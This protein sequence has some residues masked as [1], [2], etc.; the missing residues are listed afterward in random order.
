MITE[1]TEASQPIWSNVITLTLSWIIWSPFQSAVW[2][3]F[4]AYLKELGAAPSI[5]ALISSVTTVAIIFARIFG[6]YLADIIG[7][8]KMIVIFTFFIA[9]SYYAYTWFLD[10]KWVLIVGVLSNIA[11]LYQPALNAIIADSLPKKRRGFG[12]M[13]TRLADI[14]TIFAPLI[15]AYVLMLNNN[16]ITATELNLFI[17]ACV[18]GLC[19]ATLRAIGLKETIRLGKI[20]QKLSSFMIHL[21]TE[22]KR[23]FYYM[24]KNMKLYIL[25]RILFAMGFGLTAL[26][27]YYA[28]Y[29]LEISYE[30]WAI[31]VFI[32]NVIGFLSAIFSGFLTDKLGR[33]STAII[34]VISGVIGYYILATIPRGTNAT[35]YLILSFI[36]SAIM[37]GFTGIS[38]SAM[39]ADLMP[40]H[41]RGKGF[42]VLRAILDTV[43]AITTMISGILYEQV[44][45]R[46]PFFLAFLVM[47]VLTIIS[48]WIHETLEEI[49]KG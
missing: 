25:A 15:A 23:T 46:T 2:T 18:S 12:Y 49:G 16:D 40:I 11:L 34:G 35:F 39:W 37:Y 8:R 21:T 32:S 20:H 22:Y 26:T 36:A 3:Y 27:Q 19:A 14:A 13:I 44:N 24:I 31:A 41:L 30:D 43:I 28:F 45:P 5:I 1:D 33:K 48:F 4:Q 7:R 9:F 17:L 42:A 29:Y 6:G 38:F 47:L 10:W